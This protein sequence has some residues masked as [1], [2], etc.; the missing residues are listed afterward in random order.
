MAKRTENQQEK[1]SEPIVADSLKLQALSSLDEI[2]EENLPKNAWI[3]TVGGFN[4]TDSAIILRTRQPVIS[5]ILTGKYKPKARRKSN[6][7]E[8]NSSKQNP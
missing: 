6:D 3:L 2:T 5:D 4:Q 7:P 8:H 1:T